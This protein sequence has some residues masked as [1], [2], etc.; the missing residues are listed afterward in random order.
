MTSI[1]YPLNPDKSKIRLLTISSGTDRDE[2]HCSL[3]VVSLLPNPKFEALS[4]VWR[5]ATV[6]HDI[7][8]ENAPFQVTSSLHSALY[9]LRQ[10]SQPR[11]IWAD[12]L[13]INQ[14]DTRE[15]NYQ[16]PLMGSIYQSA[17]CKIA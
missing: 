8:L 17:S 3:K 9:R 11:I 12:A 6:K 15:K 7:S 1:F 16:I 14:C 4:Y 13:C 5:D 2:L 10:L